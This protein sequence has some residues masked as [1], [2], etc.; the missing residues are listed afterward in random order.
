MPEEQIRSAVVAL[1]DEDKK[2]LGVTILGSVS[3]GVW[4]ELAIEAVQLLPEDWRR[5]FPAAVVRI[6]RDDDSARQAVIEAAENLTGDLERR[7]LAIEVIK[8]PTG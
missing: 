2:N 4:H 8:N 3:L 7:Q 5:S 1:S 6:L